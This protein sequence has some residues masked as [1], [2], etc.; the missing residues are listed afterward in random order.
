VSALEDLFESVPWSGW[1]LV[2][3]PSSLGFFLKSPLR[4]NPLLGDDLLQKWMNRGVLVKRETKGRRMNSPLRC[5]WVGGRRSP[6]GNG[7]WRG[8]VRGTRRRSRGR[9]TAGL[10][11][12]GQR[13]PPR[14]KKIK[15]QKKKHSQVTT[16]FNHW[17]SRDINPMVT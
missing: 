8:G 9:V 14:K 2:S 11:I 17:W 6:V 13:V 10:W 5:P 3:F 7:D 4:E 15:K 1:S 16:S 12:L